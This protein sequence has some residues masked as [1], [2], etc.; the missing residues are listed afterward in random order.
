MANTT[1]SSL[2]CCE[3]TYSGMSRLA[4]VVLL[5]SGCASIPDFSALEDDEMYL[6]RGEEFVTDSKYLAFALEAAGAQDAMEDD[7]FDATEEYTA[8]DT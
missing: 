5:L 3:M 2:F 1:T 8:R 7:Y 6:G 4:A